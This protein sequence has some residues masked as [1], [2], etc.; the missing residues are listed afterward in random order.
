[1]T[2]EYI[3]VQLVAQAGD[4]KE[5]QPGLG[6]AF[7]IPLIAIAVMFYLM[8]LRPQRRQE[9]DR[10]AMVDAVKKNDKVVTIG[11]IVGTIVNVRREEDEVTLESGN[12]RLRILRSSIARV[13]AKS[14]AEGPGEGE[15]AGGDSESP[16]ERVKEKD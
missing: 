2:E 8:I 11:G 12:S 5:P 3:A 6:G 13:I 14:E 1:M 7:Y 10:Q 16:D 4:G 9:K 15:P